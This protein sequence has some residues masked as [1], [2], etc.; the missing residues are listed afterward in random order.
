MLSLGVCCFS[1]FQWYQ[2]TLSSTAEV[3]CS[4]KCRSSLFNSRSGRMLRQ[5]TYRS[6]LSALRVFHP[7]VLR[8]F[9]LIPVILLAGVR[10]WLP[11]S[12]MPFPNGAT[13]IVSVAKEADNKQLSLLGA[14]QACVHNLG[15]QLP[16]NSCTLVF[17]FCQS[18]KVW[19]KPL[20]CCL[21]STLK[22]HV[23]GAPW[24]KVVH[25]PRS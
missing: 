18:V 2:D 12:R 4:L 14:Q 25:K 22:R 20:Q 16:L 3:N 7:S 8:V 9:I 19:P 10:L 13:H 15:V 5:S 1:P 17:P 24:R 6:L 21:C 11:Y 23:F